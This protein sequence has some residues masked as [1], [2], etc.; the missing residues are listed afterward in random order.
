MEHGDGLLD[1]LVSA[2]LKGLEAA[3]KECDSDRT[4]GIRV[5]YNDARTLAPSTPDNSAR[6]EKILE[7]CR[8]KLGITV[9][10]MAR[11]M[12]STVLLSLSKFK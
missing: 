10:P 1:P 9:P 3:L 2:A 5:I 11:E 12:A 6:R 7:T 4:E 8:V